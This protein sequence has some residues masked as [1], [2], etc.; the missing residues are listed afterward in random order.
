MNQIQYFYD[1]NKKIM[2]LFRNRLFYK[3]AIIWPLKLEHSNSELSKL[4]DLQ[5]AKS[6]ADS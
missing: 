3:V 2:T 5:F 1:F 6:H 4:N